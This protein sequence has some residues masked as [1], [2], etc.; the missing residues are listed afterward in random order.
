MIEPPE[1]QLVRTKSEKFIYSLKEE[2][3][4][5]PSCDVQSRLCVVRL[6]DDEDFDKKL[7]EGYMYK[8]IGGNNS[9]EVILQLV[10]I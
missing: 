7:K 6:K 10:R 1:E 2:M 5:N 9:R 8:T 4:E 3:L